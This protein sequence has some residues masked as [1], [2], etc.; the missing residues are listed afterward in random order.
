[1][2]ITVAPPAEWEDYAL[3]DTGGG[4][5]LERFGRYTCV[6]PESQAL[7]SPRLASSQWEAADAEFQPGGQEERGHWAY[8]HAIEP[9]WA[10]QRGPL[11]FWVQPTPFRHLGV[12]PEQAGQWDWVAERIADAGP[13][14]SVLNLFG[15]TGL[16]SLAATHAGARVTHVDA[17]KQS[18][19]WA[20]ENQA[21]SGVDAS[22]IRWLVDD[23]SKFVAREV[24]RGA[25]YHGIILDPPKFGR[26]PKGEVWKL[27]DALPA[28][29]ADCRQLLSPHALFV[30]LNAY[31]ADMTATSLYF[32]LDDKLTG[33]GGHITAGELT[34]REQSAGR[35]LSL[36][37]F[38]R[39]AR[40]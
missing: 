21:L 22:A 19:A 10:L 27:H 7:W 26:G 32:T 11:R 30:L 6:R 28:L 17:S 16:A 8:H 23:A 38:A 9:R 29:L 20:R 18:I 14:V 4:R 3:L 40:A 25:T 37:S 5:K 12:F 15:Y 34:L 39:W 36:A 31:A 24:R 33:L 13:G 35:L 2:R 1:V